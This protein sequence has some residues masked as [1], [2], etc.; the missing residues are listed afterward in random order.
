MLLLSAVVTG[1]LVSAVV[2]GL[3]GWI[4]RLEER[5][6]TIDAEVERLK[7]CLQRSDEEQGG[8]KCTALLYGDGEPG[9]Y[10]QL[11]PVSVPALPSASGF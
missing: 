1:L 3:C 2:A 10:L 9:T 7:S 11:S 5:M 4:L 6:A 8:P